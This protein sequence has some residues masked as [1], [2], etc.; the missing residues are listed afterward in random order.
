MYSLLLS[1]MESKENTLMLNVD[2]LEE[3]NHYG[4]GKY[5][6]SAVQHMQTTKDFDEFD[7]KIKKC[8]NRESFND[9]STKNLLEETLEEC[10]CIPFSLGIIGVSIIK[11]KQIPEIMSKL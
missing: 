6:I 2:T 10:N 3:Y 4:A 8:Q 7:Q 9:C 5:M 11:N 1:E